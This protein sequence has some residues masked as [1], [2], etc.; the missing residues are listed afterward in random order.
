MD[1]EPAL[2]WVYGR[3]GATAAAV[4]QYRRLSGAHRTE[5][6]IEAPPFASI[7]AGEFP[8]PPS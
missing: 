6:G 8:L 7:V 4:E 5:L 3:L 1:L 2:I